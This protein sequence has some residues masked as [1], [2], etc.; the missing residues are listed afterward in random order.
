MKTGCN[1]LHIIF[2]IILNLT[3]TGCY[4]CS[5]NLDTKRKINPVDHS[6]CLFINVLDGNQSLNIEAEGLPRVNNLRFS[7]SVIEY[8]DVFSG[9]NNISIS[10]EKKIIIYNGFI[11]YNR[12]SAST[13]II[14]GNVNKIRLALFRDILPEC[15]GD[16]SFIRFVH[17]SADTPPVIFKLSNLSS[18]LIYRAGTEY[19]TVNSGNYQLNCTDTTTKISIVPEKTLNL[20]A[21]KIYNIILNGSNT[22]KGSHPLNLKVIETNKSN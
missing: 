20:A 15:A 16:C 5:T 10:D 11:D 3:F 19:Y 7:D 14:Y 12:D 17:L 9:R 18:T 22:I 4:E 6:H 8:Q 21:G 2:F 1:K 13:A